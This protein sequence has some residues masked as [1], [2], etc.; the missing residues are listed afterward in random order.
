M[1]SVYRVFADSFDYDPIELWVDE[2]DEYVQYGRIAFRP[3]AERQP[4]NCLY[5]NREWIVEGRVERYDGPVITVVDGADAEGGITLAELGRDYLRL[6]LDA[7]A[8][9]RIED[10]QVLA[11]FDL[12]DAEY[13]RF[14]RELVEMFEGLGVLRLQDAEP[15]DGPPNLNENSDPPP[16]SI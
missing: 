14:R 13:A 12:D 10:E 6:T 4:R 2:R 15:L 16:S 3:D 9:A 11:E 7:D 1:V 5:L 8:V